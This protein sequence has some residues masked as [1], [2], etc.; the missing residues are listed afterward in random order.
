M[1]ELLE[2]DFVPLI[3][4]VLPS[5][6]S[7]ASIE[8]EVRWIQD[9]EEASRL[10]GGDKAW[11]IIEFAPNMGMQAAFH[12]RALEAKKTGVQSLRVFLRPALTAAMVPYAGALLGLVTDSLLTFAYDEGI[13]QHAALTLPQLLGLLGYPTRAG[14]G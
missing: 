2:E 11:E 10:P 8:P 3:P 14:W 7:V 9:S 4:L 1:A 5:V 12:T 13:R 6:I